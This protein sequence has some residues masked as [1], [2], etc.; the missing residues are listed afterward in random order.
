MNLF[1]I[2]FFSILLYIIINWI[3]DWQAPLEEVEA[4]LIQKKKSTSMDAN[5]VMYTHYILVFEFNG[6]IKKFYVRRNV[7]KSYIENQIGTLKYKRR[8]FVDFII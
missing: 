6:V 3:L 4:V 7:Y 5:N 2:I 8:K 1:L